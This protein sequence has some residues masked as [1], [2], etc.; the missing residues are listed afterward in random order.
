MKFCTGCGSPLEEDVKFCT[1]CGTQCPESPAEEAPVIAEATVVE[2][3]PVIEETPAVAEAPAPKKF[4]NQ[5]GA[6]LGDTKFCTKCGAKVGAAPAAAPAPK[7]KKKLSGGKI[8]VICVAAAVLLAGIIAGI[9]A[10]L[11]YNSPEQKA[12][13]AVEEMDYEQ[14]SQLVFENNELVESELLAEALNT[15][16]E[17]IRTEYMEYTLSIQAAHEELRDIEALSVEN[18]QGNRFEVYSFISMIETS[19]IRFEN[20]K[21]Q[22]HKGDYTGAMEEFSQVI[23][24]DP[25][26]AEAQSQLE[27]SK[28]KFRQQ[29]LD[30]AAECAEVS[31]YED[32]VNTLNYALE[33]LPGDA[34]IQ[35]YLAYCEAGRIEDIGHVAMQ[36]ARNLAL[37]NKHMEAID[38]LTEV[39]KVLPADAPVV[40]NVEKLRTETIDDLRVYTMSIAQNYM[41]NGDYVKAIQLLQPV[42]AKYRSQDVEYMMDELTGAYYYQVEQQVHALMEAGEYTQADSVVYA[43]MQVL[44]DLGNFS[45]LRQEV[46]KA[47]LNNN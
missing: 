16:M 44:P 7:A 15:R 10:L 29:V 1:K 24:E 2:E 31:R 43:A 33:V 36:E 20:G 11:H 6:E 12:L 41:N 4:C 32:A 23:E 39:L 9:L 38:V 14:L 26:Y 5:C 30:Y 8:A 28:N 37:D 40:E 27:E 19:R 18:T 21:A 47:Q 35:D 17:G 25:N 42:Y 34:E 46:I 45:Q 13:R 3:V 22:F